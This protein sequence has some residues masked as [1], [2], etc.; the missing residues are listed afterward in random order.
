M[1]DETNMHVVAISTQLYKTFPLVDGVI[2]A[3]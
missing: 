1:S 2:L 3:N